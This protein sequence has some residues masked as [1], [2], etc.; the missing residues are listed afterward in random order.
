VAGFV[1]GK[2]EVSLDS[3]LVIGPVVTEGEYDR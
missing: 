2:I 3:S 1:G